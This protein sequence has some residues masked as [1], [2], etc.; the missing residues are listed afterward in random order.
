MKIIGSV[1]EDL[2]FEKRVSITPETVK[3]FTNLGFSIKTEKFSS[4]SFF[5]ISGVMEIL[6]SN[7]RSS[8]T[9]PIFIKMFKGSL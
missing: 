2:S 3:K 5:T 6:F 8:F 4:N 7:R 9:E 1:I